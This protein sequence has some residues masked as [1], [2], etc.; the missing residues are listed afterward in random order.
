MV[1]IIAAMLKSFI[2]HIQQ[3]RKS[4]PQKHFIHKML[5]NQK[6]S[7]SHSPVLSHDNGLLSATGQPKGPL[8]STGNTSLRESLVSPEKKKDQ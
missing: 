7:P 2:S 8:L 4:K 3:D 6:G 1:I 5:H